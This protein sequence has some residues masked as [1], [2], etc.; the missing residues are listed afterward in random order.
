[1]KAPALPRDTS[2]FS[3]SLAI[4]IYYESLVSRYACHTRASKRI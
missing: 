3:T 1:M 4:F 2:L